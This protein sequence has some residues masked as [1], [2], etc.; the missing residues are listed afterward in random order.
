MMPV[1]R[2]VRTNVSLGWHHPHRYFG[3]CVPP[4]SGYSHDF[5]IF[6]AGLCI[7]IKSYQYCNILYFINVVRL[8]NFFLKF[9]P[10]W[11]LN[12]RSQLL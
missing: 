3:V 11:D 8:C 6:T 1:P 12:L 7:F 5:V 9:D 4:E 2:M 10:I